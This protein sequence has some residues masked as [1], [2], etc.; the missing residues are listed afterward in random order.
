[1]EEINGIL[2]KDPRISSGLLAELNKFDKES[3]REKNVHAKEAIGAKWRNEGVACAAIAALSD[4]DQHNTKTQSGDESSLLMGS[5]AISV[6]E[7]T[8]KRLMTQIMIAANKNSR[9]A[10]KSL[11]PLERKGR[12]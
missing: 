5:G 7:E 1:M 2:A 4:V 3:Q 12:R 8:L 6:P 9:I 11:D 10:A